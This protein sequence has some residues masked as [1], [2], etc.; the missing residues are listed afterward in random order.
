MEKFNKK[1]V[2][3]YSV[4]RYFNEDVSI[5]VQNGAVVINAPWFFTNNKIRKIIEEKKN[6]ILN[7]IK[8]YEKESQET[9]IRNEIVKILGEDCKV[10][11]NYK[12]LKK[13]TLTLEGRNLT[14]CLP[15]KYKKITEH[16][17]K[18]W[19]WRMP[20]FMSVSL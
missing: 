14:I 10:I 6:I 1:E 4:N 15:N 17:K 13:P 20:D 18:R 19:M 16:S 9:F 2:I 3:I 11:V 8:E 5:N 12:N 7:K